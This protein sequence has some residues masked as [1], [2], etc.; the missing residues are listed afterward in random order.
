L[1]DLLTL[2]QNLDFKDQAL[3]DFIVKCVRS[4]IRRGNVA[5]T[6]ERAKG[7][8][9][10]ILMDIVISKALHIFQH[11]KFNWLTF[12]NSWKMM[13][14]HLTPAQEVWF[15]EVF[16]SRLNVDNYL[17]IPELIEFYGLDFL[18]PIYEKLA[19]EI[20]ESNPNSMV[21]S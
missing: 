7:N 6:F 9:N 12:F 20:R 17:K 11:L 4:L 15:M 18:K 13:N 16:M 8:N 5:A 1:I 2:I 14:D 19:Q 3:E 10:F 21:L